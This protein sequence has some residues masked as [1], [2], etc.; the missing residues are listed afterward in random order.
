M[1][2]FFKNHAFNGILKLISNGCECYIFMI[3]YKW[4]LSQ[5]EQI[6]EKLI[7]VFF[8]LIQLFLLSIERFIAT[9]S[10]RTLT[11]TDCT[12]YPLMVFIILQRHLDCVIIIMKFTFLFVMSHLYNI[13]S[14][15]FSLKLFVI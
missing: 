8:F 6:V 5:A 9:D 14:C 1:L 13:I 3:K 10:T 11:F 15:V 4:F 12:L 7:N 2:P